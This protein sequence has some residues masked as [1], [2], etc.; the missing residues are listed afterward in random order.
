MAAALLFPTA[1][2]ACPSFYSALDFED[3]QQL[4]LYRDPEGGA[5]ADV[6]PRRLLLGISGSGRVALWDFDRWAR[7]GVA[8]G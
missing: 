8:K 1:H 2:S 6:P 5:A 7:D 3:L 4:Q